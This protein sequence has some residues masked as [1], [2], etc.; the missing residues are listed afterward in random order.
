MYLENLH[1]CLLLSYPHNDYRRSRR[2]A[3]NTYEPK[4]GEKFMY[5]DIFYAIS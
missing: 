4:F 1:S 3:N 2:R 5:P